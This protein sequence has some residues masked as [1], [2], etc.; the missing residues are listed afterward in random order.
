MDAPPFYLKRNENKSALL[1]EGDFN[2]DLLQVSIFSQR[3]PM[4]NRFANRHLGLAFLNSVVLSIRFDNFI[5]NE[6]VVWFNR[7]KGSLDWSVWRLENHL[8]R[9]YT[10]KMSA[11]MAGNVL[12]PIL[13]PAGV[14]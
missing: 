5:A 12:Q 2:L 3:E 14:T 11:D 13:R 1:V 9:L 7:N 4:A 8:T 6:F 10:L